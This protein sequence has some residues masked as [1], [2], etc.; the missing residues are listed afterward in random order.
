MT[1]SHNLL[2]DRSVCRDSRR[3]AW[4]LDC[5]KSIVDSSPMVI[6]IPPDSVIVRTSARTWSL[7]AED[8]DTATLPSTHMANRTWITISAE[9]S[10]GVL[11]D[12][13]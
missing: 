4:R 3:R 8:W 11:A 2:R 5:G 1:A 13:D 9:L 12:W 10:Q 6:D 7:D